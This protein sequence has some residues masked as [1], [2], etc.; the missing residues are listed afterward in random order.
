MEKMIIFSDLD[1]TL[2]DHH[3]YSFRA[4]KPALELMAERRIPL[5]LTSSKS[6]AE[7]KEIQEELN[8]HH[9][10]IVEN[11]GAI[12]IPKEY[13]KSLNNL[14]V[15]EGFLIMFL[16]PSYDEI[17]Q[18]LQKIKEKGE[19]S[20]RGFNDI[21]VEEVISLTGLDFDKA[22][23]AKTRLCSEP[24]IWE[25]SAEK[26][27][28]FEQALKKYDFKLL[29]GG[30]FY[31]LMGNTDKGNA[32]RYLMELYKEKYPGIQSTTVGVGD[33]PNDIEML[34]QV[35]IPILVKRPDNTYIDI[36][37]KKE[38]VYAEGIG[39]Q[40]WN[41]AIQEVLSGELNPRA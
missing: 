28:Q 21:R 26:L 19:Y 37:M 18:T 38:I 36:T 13:F 20:F 34:R 32:V 33:S 6:L 35:D 29:K 9:P 12:C 24:I 3:T 5:I 10:F 1:G 23:K 16:G 30:R 40:G 27:R 2:L 15:V 31:H 7:I 22:R 17:L 4:A 25:D 39:P 8:L 41:K 14:P 11:G